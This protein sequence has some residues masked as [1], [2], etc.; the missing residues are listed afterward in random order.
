MITS[1]F[2]DSIRSSFHVFLS[3][4]TVRP[5]IT[6]ISFLSQLQDVLNPVRTV[7][8]DVTRQSS[9][10]SAQCAIVSCRDNFVIDFVRPLIQFVLGIVTDRPRARYCQSPRRETKM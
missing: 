6:M 7:A 10:W 5:Y 8:P 1:T 3:M 4:P 2:Y 9:L